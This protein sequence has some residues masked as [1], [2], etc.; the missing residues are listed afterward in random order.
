MTQQSQ[1]YGLLI[2]LFALAL[3][4]RRTLTTQTVRVWALLAVPIFIV[5]VGI[6]VIAVT[7]P[8]SAL[9]VGILII[10][11][12]AGVGLGYA[13]GIHSRVELGPRP[14]TI[15]VQGNVLL[16]IILV[17]AFVVRYAVRGYVGGGHTGIVV[18]DAFILF[19]AAS[20]GVARAMLF[21]TYRR[22]IVARAT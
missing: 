3:I 9:D 5:V 7:P 14:G 6:S 2:G 22:L 21:V 10:A 8:T 4:V 17:V 18:S 1:T 13:R 15:I 19:A 20:V 12:L 11:T 16:V